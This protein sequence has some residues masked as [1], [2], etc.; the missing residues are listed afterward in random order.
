MKND[1][2]KQEIS[3]DIVRDNTFNRF[4]TDEMIYSKINNNIEISFMQYGPSYSKQITNNGVARI[5]S[6]NV[7]TEVAR[8]RISS[9]TITTFILN[10]I[11]KEANSGNLNLER[12]IE[13]IK[14]FHYEEKDGEK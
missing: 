4:I 7:L 6:N 1:Q 10:F 13:R 2:K 12:L 3:F 14:N 9:T 5:K 8:T 11:K